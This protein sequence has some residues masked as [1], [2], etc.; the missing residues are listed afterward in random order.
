MTLYV[1]SNK[2]KDVSVHGV[3]VGS[4]NTN[5]ITSVPKNINLTLS[6]GTLTLKAGSKVYVPNGKNADGSNRFDEVVVASDISGLGWSTL[7]GMFFV[8]PSKKEILFSGNTQ[9]A[10]GSSHTLSYLV[11]R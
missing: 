7:Q 10:S 5:V 11:R 8:S 1:G 4:Q 9:I 3:Y 2:I 6:N